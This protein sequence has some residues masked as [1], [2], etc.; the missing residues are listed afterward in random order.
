MKKTALLCV[1]AL[2][3]GCAAGLL[4]NFALFHG[5][6]IH[7]PADIPAA[8]LVP[9]TTDAPEGPDPADNTPLLRASL[10]VLEALKGRDYSALAALV[11]PEKGVT[12]TPYSTVDPEADITLTRDEIA[13]AGEN[14]N[15]YT[16]GS[17]DGSGS[18]IHLTISAYMDQYVFNADYT[19][20]PLVGVDQVLSSGN[21]L[22][23]VSDAYP[24][25]RFVEYYFPSVDP[26]SNGFD[27]CGLKLV[28]EVW[29]GQYRLVGVVH[30][31]WTI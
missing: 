30:S 11:H 8:S 2:L 14:G 12:F 24:G 27:W 16:W 1:L 13:Q 15:R 3:I 19:Q 5:R 23:N 17:Y 4:G 29:R 26:A 20:A 10:K 22:E 6:G 7:A 18:P 21:S 9:L 25:G 28:F 31:E